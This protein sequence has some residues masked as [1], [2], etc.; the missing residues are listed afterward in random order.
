M[1]V[2]LFTW[3]MSA[4]RMS[5]ANNIGGLHLPLGKILSMQTDEI[6]ELKDTET[7]LL[8]PERAKKY[9]GH[10]NATNDGF[11]K[12]EKPRGW[13]VGVAG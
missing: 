6:D 8:L 1:P 11:Q 7:H 5:A 13:N 9:A 3:W 10:A 2:N 12:C 4:N